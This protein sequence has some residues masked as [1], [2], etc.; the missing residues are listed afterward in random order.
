MTR[1]KWCKY[2]RGEVESKWFFKFWAR[3]LSPWVCGM[4]TT[5]SSWLEKHKHHIL[6]QRLSL[7]VSLFKRKRYLSLTVSNCWKDKSIFC[8]WGEAMYLCGWTMCLVNAESKCTVPSHFR[9]QPIERIVASNLW[10]AVQ[11]RPEVRTKMYRWFFLLEIQ[12]WAMRYRA[13]RQQPWR[14]QAFQNRFWLSIGRKGY[15]LSYYT[16]QE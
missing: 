16:M 4:S 7:D 6:I 8:L 3:D 14:S 2:K 1:T 12:H 9:F 10:A 13:R 11:L 15:F 5:R